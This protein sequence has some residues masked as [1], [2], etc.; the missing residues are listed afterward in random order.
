MVS[1]SMVSDKPIFVQILLGTTGGCA[2]QLS[3]REDYF[4]HPIT[5]MKEKGYIPEVWTLEKGAPGNCR[6]ARIRR[7][8]SA[9]FLVLNLLS[10]KKVK[11][12]H[13]HLRPY[14]PSL[15]SGLLNKKCVLTPHTYMLGSSWLIKKFSLMLMKQFDRIIALTPHERQIYLDNGITSNKVRLI[16]HPIDWDFFSKAHLEPTEKI[17]KRYNIY[18]NEFVITTVANFRRIKNLETMLS[19]FQKF[20]YY[21]KK[22]KFIVVG[23]NQL[24]NKKYSEQGNSRGYALGINSIVKQLGDKVIFTGGIGYR[25][26]RKILAISDIYVN[27]SDLEAMCLSVYEAASAGVPLCLSKIG[28]FTSVFGDM[29]LYS[30]PRDEKGLLKNFL[31]YFENPVLRNKSGNKLSRFA[32]KWDY[33]LVMKDLKVLYKELTD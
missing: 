7:F 2:D 19:A 16:P 10:N 25:Q 15:L 5:V 21:N 1:G 13:A 27:N 32:K 12:I 4:L 24:Q 18:D 14:L 29:A 28:S 26:V 8:S 20:L 6:G 3:P 9:L 17:R 33:P 23:K 22:S 31:K 11:L 30:E